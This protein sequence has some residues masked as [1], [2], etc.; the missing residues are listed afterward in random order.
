MINLFLPIL[1]VIRLVNTIKTGLRDPEYRALAFWIVTLI[2]VGTVFYS[3]AEDWTWIDALYFS[4]I[5]LTTVGYGDLSPTTPATKLFTI[6]YIVLGLSM[7]A[8]F[9]QL[10]A[11]K[12]REIQQQRHAQKQQQRNTPPPTG[13]GVE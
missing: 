6:L 13:D 3:L 10:T 2:G 8:G 9:I 7:F 12:Q 4:V 1:L 5:T 11:Q